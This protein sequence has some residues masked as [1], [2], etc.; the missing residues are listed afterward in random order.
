[1]PAMMV[2]AVGISLIF[3]GDGNPNLPNDPWSRLVTA[4]DKFWYVVMMLVLA[5]C[6]FVTAFFCC[7]FVPPMI[8]GVPNSTPRDTTGKIVE[9]SVFIGSMGFGAVLGYVGMGLIS[10][11]F[12]SAE[13][14]SRW[15]Q[16]F[17]ARTAN[18]SPL[19]KKIWFCGQW[20]ML[21]KK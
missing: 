3:R 19:L 21:P 1:M 4:G 13:T 6:T 9:L 2:M 20:Y 5:V 11:K 16:E 17:E 18:M 7:M 8:L 14:H 15:A 10:H 12:I